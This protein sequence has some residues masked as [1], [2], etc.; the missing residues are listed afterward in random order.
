MKVPGWITDDD[1]LA[2]QALITVTEPTDISAYPESNLVAL[3]VSATTRFKNRASNKIHFSFGRA[4]SLDFVALVAHNLSPTATLTLRAGA[5]YD[6]ATLSEA[7]AWRRRT[8]FVHLSAAAAHRYWSI[9]ITDAANEHPYLE[10]GYLVAGVLDV[11][12]YGPSDEWLSSDRMVQVLGESDTG[13]PN[14]RALSERRSVAMLFEALSVGEAAEARS[15]FLDLAGRKTPLFFVPDTLVNDGFFGRFEQ[16]DLEIEHANDIRRTLELS[17]LEDPAGLSLETVHWEIRTGKAL[18]AGSVFT[19]A[20]TAYYKNR[21]LKLVQ[22]AV[23][24]LRDPHYL[25]PGAYGILFEPT[26]VNRFTYSEDLTDASYVVTNASITADAASAPTLTPA[27]TADKLVEAADVSKRHRV[28][29]DLSS[30][31]DDTVQSVSFFA[32]AAERSDL[33][34]RLITK[35]GNTPTW[36]VNL[37]TGAAA[38]DVGVGSEILTTEQYSNGWW[39][40]LI[41]GNI[42]NGGTTPQVEIRLV[43]GGTEQYDGD[44]SSGC[45]LWGFQYER[46]EVWPTSYI[47]TTGSEATRNVDNLQVPLDYDS[48][49]PLTGLFS[50]YDIGEN[51][52]ASPNGY[53]I[54]LGHRTDPNADPRVAIRSKGAGFNFL[55][56]DGTST[57]TALLSFAADFG[58][59]VEIRFT[60]PPSGVLVVGESVEGDAED[61]AS[62]GTF[63]FAAAGAWPEQWATIGNQP[64]GDR[65]ALIVLR[66]LVVAHNVQ[67][68]AVMRAL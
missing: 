30:A 26:R 68:Q 46:D 31:A 67:T 20:S 57:P 63:D 16:S 66:R 19:R 7:I 22:A 6:A 40:V 17:L 48:P 35:A 2:R 29:R 5:S 9:A 36:D 18:P 41:R 56:D 32:K 54:Q 55:A 27:T 47:A 3:P 65:G 60:L 13:T 50:Y 45:Y 14:I 15:L 42:E 53:L 33:S 39:R 24:E 37:V 38:A 10:A 21:D 52:L 43:A 61:T 51:K 62:A 25:A 44:G 34:V 8:A 23:D 59:A 4:V 64:G 28:A 12:D 1:N 58:E 11:Y 49:R